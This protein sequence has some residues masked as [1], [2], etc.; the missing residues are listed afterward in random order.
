MARM[1][2]MNLIIRLQDRA[3][4][5]MRRIS[6]D[7]SALSRH[8][9]AM[10]KL[11]SMQAASERN[12]INIAKQRSKLED[13]QVST[14][15]KRNRNLAQEKTLQAELIG[16]QTALN[17]L[18]LTES[19]LVEWTAMTERQRIA[20]FPAH[21]AALYKYQATQARIK[22]LVG[23]T[24][25][26]EMGLVAE[27]NAATAAQNRLNA[28]IAKQAPL[29]AKSEVQAARYTRGRSMA[30]AGSLMFMGGAVTTGLSGLAASSY[31]KFDISAT[32]AAT[33]VGALGNNAAQTTVQAKE[34]EK[35]IL[36]MAT[37]FPASAD[38][39]AQATYDI[40]SSMSL[41]STAVEQM[42]NGIKLLEV[43]NKAAVGGQIDLSTA[44]N[45]MITVLND[46]NPSLKDI[47]N[48]MAQLFATVRFM[49]GGFGDLGEAMNKLA[50][51]A[52]ASGQSLLEVGSAIAQVTRGIPSQA[53]SGTA[54]ARLL[55]VFGRPDFQEGMRKFSEKF[56]KDFDIT[57]VA[58]DGTEKLVPLHEIISK[59]VKLSPKLVN[60]G[61]DLQNVIKIITQLGSP[62]GK[63]G[64]QSTVQA[65]RALTELIVGYTN[66]RNILKQSRRDTEEYDKSVKALSETAGVKWQISM[67]KLRVAWIQ[68]GQAAMPIL[69]KVLDG[70]TKLFD[71]FNG[72]STKNKNII[73]SLIVI[74]GLL[75]TVGGLFL[76][77]FGGIT[78]VLAWNR[79]RMLKNA[80]DAIQAGAAAA[81]TEV[82]ALSKATGALALMA[83][84]GIVIAVTYLMFKKWSKESRGDFFAG[85]IDKSIKNWSK[86]WKT[87]L[88]PLKAPAS[89]IASLDA[90]MRGRD[91]K[92]PLASSVKDRKAVVDNA[93]KST[94]GITNLSKANDIRKVYDDKYL[95]WAKT[96]NGIQTADAKKLADYQKRLAK[97]VT[98]AK[99]QALKQ[100]Q[101]DVK[102]MVNNLM[103]TYRALEATNRQGTDLF[104]GPISG[105][106]VLG[107]FADINQT[108][109]SLGI[110]PIKIP[111]EFIL[112]D[113]QMQ[114]SNFEDWRKGLDTLA[115]KLGPKYRGMVLEL[116][117]QGMAS[118]PQVVSMAAAKPAQLKQWKE[119]WAKMQVMVE[120]ATKIDMG[121]TLDY[122]NSFG[123][124]AA[125]QFVN[126]MIQSGA[127]V[128]LREQFA[129]M[130]TTSF[131]GEL[132]K[133]M[134]DAVAQAISDWK[135]NNPPPKTTATPK[136][137][138][139]PGSRGGSGGVPAGS[140]NDYP[141]ATDTPF[142]ITAEMYK[143][144]QAYHGWYDESNPNLQRRSS[145]SMG[146]GKKGGSGVGS[147]LR[148]VGRIYGKIAGFGYASG[149]IIPGSGN[150]DSVPAMLTP[151][152]VVLNKRQVGNA[153][154]MLGTA[155]HPQ[156]V[157]NK[158][159]HFAKGGVAAAQNYMHM[160]GVSI[161]QDP[162]SGAIS[163]INGAGVNYRT[164]MPGQSGWK[165]LNR[166]TLGHQPTQ[167]FAKDVV[168]IVK[169]FTNV[170][171]KKQAADAWE[172]VRH[173][174]RRLTSGGM[175]VVPGGG[176]VKPSGIFADP[177]EALT[178]ASLE[179]RKT[180][181]AA[182]KGKSSVVK[183]VFAGVEKETGI[184]LSRDISP[185]EMEALWKR[186]EKTNEYKGP[187]NQMPD[188][189]LSKASRAA[190]LAR[191]LEK[192]R[193]SKA[194]EAAR[195][196]DKAGTTIADAIASGGAAGRKYLSDFESF[197]DNYKQAH[198][199]G[200]PDV[201]FMH[202][203]RYSKRGAANLNKLN[204]AAKKAKLSRE[205]A[206]RTTGLT[207][208]G[209]HEPKRGAAAIPGTAGGLNNLRRARAAKKARTAA[210]VDLSRTGSTRPRPHATKLGEV[211]K[212]AQALI[213]K[214]AQMAK[215]EGVIKEHSSDTGSGFAN[216]GNIFQM[217]HAVT[218]ELWSSI[219]EAFSTIDLVHGFP[220]QTI[221]KHIPLGTLL[222]DQLYRMGVARLRYTDKNFTELASNS[223]HSMLIKDLGVLSEP[224]RATVNDPFISMVET[225]M[226]EYG[227]V[228]DATA[229]RGKKM[230]SVS[231]SYRYP[232]TMKWLMDDMQNTKQAGYLRLTKQLNPDRT[233]HINYLLSNDEMFARA[234]VQWL[235]SI[236][237]HKGLRREISSQVEKGNPRYWEYGEFKKIGNRMTDLFDD[238]DMLRFT[239]DRF[240][241]GGWVKGRG[242]NDTVPAWLT[243][244]E[245]VVSKPM[246]N[247]LTNSK[248]NAATT[249]TV[250]HETNINVDVTN[251]TG[252]AIVDALNPVLFGLRHKP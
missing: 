73:A 126:G 82:T 124:S 158:V 34:L 181:L 139:A 205:R 9:Q 30:H 2:E 146:A 211:D 202:G 108:L 67:N 252:K 21:Q 220:T 103:S 75:A 78:M 91:L 31:A 248:G 97:E 136:A 188:H 58:A 127:E 149:G 227:H 54:I 151:G 8:A 191:T 15:V 57:K 236:T 172:G 212:G 46:F 94:F 241:Q 224:A 92:H 96:V 51:A 114:L 193:T 184:D 83:R 61:V 11:S 56:N 39:M 234:Y 209:P 77:A 171:L 116:Q 157:F 190:D 45:T 210:G 250:T 138:R 213:A 199:E 129:S 95:A 154:A 89:A 194:A 153:S 178:R 163:V 185:A 219:Q 18:R 37:R 182:R 99:Q 150:R 17:K 203:E 49:R 66:Y 162:K 135:E 180:A 43:A 183:K 68:F 152:E 88:N 201:A 156:A 233:K 160:K 48:T 79:M 71:R 35:A 145:T 69:L 132:T 148:D 12:A 174:I 76:S 243:P 239:P 85:G 196:T 198:A 217:K 207:G 179:A 238:A 70:F 106:P 111:V 131:A 7:M 218:P 125:Y 226:H 102:S 52:H 120:D 164:F 142:G 41:G 100:Q 130:I 25:E 53:Q 110:K 115:K 33:Q 113:Q 208:A 26:E 133:S 166:Y 140:L 143:R 155:N 206:R 1:Y 60:G 159:Q 87:S 36:G 175:M 245:Y 223:V 134:T 3:S 222:T 235:A 98:T 28:S 74:A 167:T 107:A 173:P 237:G 50:P 10:N 170:G 177:G 128:K 229:F 144:N 240:K 221:R 59:I 176:K 5:R 117:K 168:G 141:W 204:A 72:M 246:I 169:S 214:L 147:Y 230:G 242:N 13:M 29:M 192:R 24:T 47:D 81:T 23:Q 225:I 122:Y 19:E 64:T 244:G 20:N 4:A 228:L 65:R 14:G 118:M 63:G 216:T 165:E 121:T 104:G 38:D 80:I 101:D 55:D 137:P 32:K 187:A 195:V 247:S 40:F 84:G 119:N 249:H 231:G 62:T 105:G 200:Y 232:D 86:D 27:I 6:G 215:D 189:E 90:F 44:T 251:P 22:A 93:G 112:Q 197:L 42:A 123:K 186:V 109:M 16:R 161:Q